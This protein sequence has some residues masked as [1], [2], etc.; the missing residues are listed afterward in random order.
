MINL[1]AITRIMAE[2]PLHDLD[3]GAGGD[4]EASGCV[5]QRVR[6]KSVQSDLPRRRREDVA[7]EVARAQHVTLWRREHEVVG[8]KAVHVFPKHVSEECWNADPPSGVRLG[9]SPRQRAIDRGD[10]FGDLDASGEH[11]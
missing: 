2:H 4:C 9:R 6:H 11:V 5:S 1:T 10:R 7:T 3:V 8:A